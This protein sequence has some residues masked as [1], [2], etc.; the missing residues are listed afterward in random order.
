MGAI[1]KRIAAITMPRGRGHGAWEVAVFG[2]KAT[3]IVTCALLLGTAGAVS[4]SP[5]TPYVVTIEQVGANVVATGSGEFNLTGLTSSESGSSLTPQVNPQFP[6]LILSTGSY[7]LYDVEGV[8][9]PSNFGSGGTTTASSS[10]GPVVVFGLA[11]S[12]D[13]IVPTGYT[14]GTVLAPSTDTFDSTT[15]ALMGINVGTYEWTW[16]AAADQSFTIDVVATPV[17]A[18]FS[19][20][21]TGLGGLGLFGWRRK[22]KVQSLAA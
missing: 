3:I 4:A 17:P 9:G 12:S 6:H 13:L 14:S 20:F 15:L 2:P 1:M 8:T 5:V 22:R 19:L 18:A 11:V 21:A 7:I 10:S 16:G